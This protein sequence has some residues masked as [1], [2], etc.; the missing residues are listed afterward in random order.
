MFIEGK[1]LIGLLVETK[2]GLV[3][4]KIKDFEIDGETHTI[5]RYIVRS[6]NLIG[7]LLREATGELVVGR[8]Q[9]I[10]VDEAKMV[11]ENGAVKEMEKV[12]MA[13]GAGKDAPALTSSRLSFKTDGE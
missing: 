1:N 5:E 13:A 10:S 8:S 6:R 4:G 3:L 7:K 2:D 12:M 9:V 11:V